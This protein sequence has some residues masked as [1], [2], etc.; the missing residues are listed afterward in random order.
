[1]VYNLP[2]SEDK[3]VT[4]TLSGKL[5][6][7]A[8]ITFAQAVQVL[9]LLT[10]DAP[11]PSGGIPLS[12]PA[13]GVRSSQRQDAMSPKEALEASGAK[14][15]AEKIA[16]FAALVTRQSG[17]DTFSLDDVKPLFKQARE[18]TPG[19]LTRDLNV[20]IQNGWIAEAEDSG[21]YYLTGKVADVLDNSFGG[22]RSGKSTGSKPRSPRPRRPSKPREVPEVFAGAEVS[23]VI[24]G[25]IDFHKIKVKKDKYLW[26]VNAAKL[27]GVE[28]VTPAE[29]VWLSDK[30]GEMLPSGDLGGHFRGNHKS[31][32]VN[33]NAQDK[34]RITPA[35]EAHLKELTAGNGK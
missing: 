3:D 10:S 11:V 23:P 25:L 13:G 14:V 5:S 19:N 16:A 29:L 34:V 18:T 17:R 33:K 4:L 27:L 30:L 21:E 26:A 24:D 1:M 22:L 9:T 8:E 2:M 12:G 7:S 15:N 6:Y 20:A 32:Y 28:A 31:G 35:G